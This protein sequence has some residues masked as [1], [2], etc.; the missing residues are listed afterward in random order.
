MKSVAKNKHGT[1]LRITKKSF[2]DK[3]LPYEVFLTTKENKTN[4]KNEKCF[5]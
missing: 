3:E 4:K 5:W 1:T 2:S